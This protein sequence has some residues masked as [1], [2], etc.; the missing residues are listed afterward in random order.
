MPDI[1]NVQGISTSTH[2][3]QL[4]CQIAQ[5]SVQIMNVNCSRCLFVRVLEGRREYY[6]APLAIL[7]VTH[8]MRLA[9]MTTQGLETTVQADR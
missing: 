3:E 7:P 9:E 4:V 2:F 6:I 1:L 5:F 8:D